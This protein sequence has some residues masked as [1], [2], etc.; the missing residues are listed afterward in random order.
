MSQKENNS[1]CAPQRQSMNETVSVIVPVYNAQSFLKKCIISIL[2]QTYS[3]LQLILID[4]GSSDNSLKICYRFAE[5]DNRVLVLS[6][7]ITKILLP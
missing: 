7:I 3:D 1:H 2:E 4:D 5:K 6:Q